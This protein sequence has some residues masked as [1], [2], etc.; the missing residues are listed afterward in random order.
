MGS[1]VVVEIGST[2]VERCFVVLENTVDD[3]T[4]GGQRSDGVF[5]IKAR[6]TSIGTDVVSNDT[7]FHNKTEDIF[8]PDSR[9]ITS[10]VMAFFD[11]QIDEFD[12]V[13]CYCDNMV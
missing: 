13:T 1:W 10:S 9:A 4:R 2:S 6:T 11:D 5:K 7:S 12:K 3:E 8:C